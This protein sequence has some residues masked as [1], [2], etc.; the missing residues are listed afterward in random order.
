MKCSCGQ[1]IEDGEVFNIIINNDIVNV[2]AN[3]WW[4]YITN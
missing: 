4:N 2:C 1:E 3:C